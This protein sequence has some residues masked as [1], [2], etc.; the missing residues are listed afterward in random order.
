MLAWFVGDVAFLDQLY[1]SGGNDIL[2]KVLM[3]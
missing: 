3:D 1:A 2:K